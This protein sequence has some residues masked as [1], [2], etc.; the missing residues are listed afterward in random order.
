MDYTVIGDAVNTA[1]RLEAIAKECNRSIVM[2]SA[3]AEQ[4]PKEWKLLSLGTFA[5]RGQGHQQVFALETDT[6]SIL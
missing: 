2:S 6:D 1:S 5:I 3:V 4:L